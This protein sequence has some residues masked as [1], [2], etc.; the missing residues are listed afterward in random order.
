MSVFTS[1]T[2]VFAVAPQLGPQ[3]MDAAAQAGFKSVICNRPDGE[4]GREQP[5][6]AEMRAAAEQAGLK[7]VYM[8]VDGANIQADDVSQMGELLD[9]LPTPVL[10]YCRSGGRSTKLFMLATTGA[11]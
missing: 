9:T 7:F 4:G 1:I 6:S 5:L 3:D 2:P 8:P 10:A 11:N